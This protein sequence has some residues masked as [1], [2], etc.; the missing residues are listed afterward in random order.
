MFVKFRF[1]EK[2]VLGILIINVTKMLPTIKNS[3][4]KNFLNLFS[5]ICVKIVAKFNTSLL[6]RRTI[7]DGM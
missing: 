4:D 1:M 6:S 3:P 5:P 2:I 7:E